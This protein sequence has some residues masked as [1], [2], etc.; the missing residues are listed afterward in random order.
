MPFL[1]AV[2]VS[3]PVRSRARCHAAAPK[4][5]GAFIVRTGILFIVFFF[6]GGRGYYSISITRT[7][8]EY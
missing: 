4:S 5:F 1:L 8:R 2:E 6:G 7:I 3:G